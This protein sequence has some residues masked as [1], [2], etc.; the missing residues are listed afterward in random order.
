MAT[1]NKRTENQRS[2]DRLHD[3]ALWCKKSDL[4]GSI[5]EFES[6]CGMGTKYLT[7]TILSAKGSVGAEI[8]ERVYHAFPMVNL[9]WVITGEGTMI[10]NQIYVK[11]EK[12]RIENLAEER[13]RLEDD[14]V[15]LAKKRDQVA[16]RYQSFSDLLD[17]ANKMRKLLRKIPK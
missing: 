16:E 14:I 15:D 9:V 7:N 8:L 17:C 11:M 2:I 10:N 12:T 6:K 1:K 13:K 5:Y 3:F 4:V